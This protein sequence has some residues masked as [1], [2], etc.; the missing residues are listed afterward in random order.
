MFNGQLCQFHGRK[1]S[2]LPRCRNFGRKA[3]KYVKSIPLPKTIVDPW[4]SRVSAQR[5]PPKDALRPKSSTSAH[6]AWRWRQ[7]SPCATPP[8]AH[9]SLVVKQIDRGGRGLN[10]V[11]LMSWVLCFDILLKKWICRRC[12]F[13][14][15]FCV[16]D[17]GTWWIDKETVE[18]PPVSG[19]ERPRELYVV[20]FRNLQPRSH[21]C[22]GDF[23]GHKG[24][25]R[26]THMSSKNNFVVLGNCRASKGITRMKRFVDF[27]LRFLLALSFESRFV[28]TLTVRVC[29]EFFF[30]M[31][32][33]VVRTTLVICV[34]QSAPRKKNNRSNVQWQ[35]RFRLSWIIGCVHAYLSSIPQCQPIGMW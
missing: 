29:R 28:S 13:T 33:F 19:N 32:I 12:N 26:E 4:P 20:D 31:F 18:V 5:P 16:D 10:L 23:S 11:S 35:Q 9:A 14:V 22:V 30:H 17:G 24:T 8:C 1:W 3:L 25:Q 7:P 15:F 2:R 27:L 21:V 34:T 6:T